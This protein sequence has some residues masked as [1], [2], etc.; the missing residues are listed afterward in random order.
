MNTRLLLLLAL[1]SLPLSGCASRS[2]EKSRANPKDPDTWVWINPLRM[3]GVK[4][5]TLVRP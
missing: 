1:L 5:D 4:H 3:A 2:E